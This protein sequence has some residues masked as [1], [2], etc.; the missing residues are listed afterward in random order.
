[1]KNIKAAFN[2]LN[3][4]EG[5]RTPA[6]RP[7]EVTYTTMLTGI[8]RWGSGKE[9][10]A[11]HSD[12][13][14]RMGKRGIRFNRATCHILIR[15]SLEGSSRE[16]P[17]YA[18]DHFNRMTRLKIEPDFDTWYTILDGMLCRGEIQIANDLVEG[19]ARR[20]YEPT[21]ALS[22]LVNRIRSKR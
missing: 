9:S 14:R 3:R 7:N 19:M 21:G 16:G 12:I 8:Y 10:E 13:L 20:R 11:Y 1:M 6:E 2:I 17:R 5:E 15:A 18:L 4:M 22:G